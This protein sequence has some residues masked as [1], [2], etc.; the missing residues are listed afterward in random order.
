MGTLGTGQIYPVAWCAPKAL[1][2][3]C[4]RHRYGIVTGLPTLPWST[5]KLPPM[6][7]GHSGGHLSIKIIVSSPS[8]Q[9]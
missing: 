4:K 9:T 2:P 1:A 6:F 3:Q 8:G 5:G 7:S